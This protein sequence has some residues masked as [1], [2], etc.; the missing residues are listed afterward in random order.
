MSCYF[1]I[2]SPANGFCSFETKD[3]CELSNRLVGKLHRGK[4]SSSIAKE[5]QFFTCWNPI[6]QLITRKT[7]VD[8]VDR[9]LL[10]HQ[11]ETIDLLEVNWWDYDNFFY[12]NAISYLM[13]LKD[14]EKVQNIGVT[15]FDTE[16]LQF[17]LEEN[18]P[19]VSNK[20]CRQ[21]RPIEIYI[22]T[23]LQVSFSLIDTR[24]KHQLLRICE[25]NDIKLLCEECLLV[26]SNVL[27]LTCN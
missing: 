13:E 9:I 4:L 23:D 7:V 5:C 10:Q 27:G 8:V 20:V 18:A 11:R 24:A 3:F 14:E 2:G 6:P 12:F 16:H 1:L 15:N 25:K 21:L 22:N 26:R 17:L 19:I